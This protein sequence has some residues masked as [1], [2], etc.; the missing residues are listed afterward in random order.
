M[1]MLNCAWVYPCSAA[2]PYHLGGLHVVLGGSFPRG[3]RS[4]CAELSVSVSLVARPEVPFH[5]LTVVFWD[6]PPAPTVCSPKHQLGLSVSLLGGQ[7][8]PLHR[9]PVVHRH[10]LAFAVQLAKD[11]LG[12]SESLLGGLPELLNGL[13]LG[14]SRLIP[15]QND[16]GSE[17]KDYLP[18]ASGSVGHD[19][20]SLEVDILTLI[21]SQFQRPLS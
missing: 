7:P 2:S 13:V 9:L 12:L 1:P 16:Q 11:L 17:E 18:S 8:V 5:S 19:F 20:P 3:V 10:S 4:A 15:G 21:G 6:T 14:E